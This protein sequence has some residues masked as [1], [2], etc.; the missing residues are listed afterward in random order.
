MEHRITLKASGVISVYVDNNAAIAY[1]AGL[2][3]AGIAFSYEL[4]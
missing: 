3:R 1:I 2:L 4:A